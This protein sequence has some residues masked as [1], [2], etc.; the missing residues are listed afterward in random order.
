MR[1]CIDTWKEAG[2]LAYAKTTKDSTSARPLRKKVSN[3]SGYLTFSSSSLQFS[4]D[5]STDNRSTP[6]NFDRSTPKPVSC[7]CEKP[8]IIGEM[9]SGRLDIQT[10]WTSNRSIWTSRS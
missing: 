2:S 8:M 6:Q 9:W 4:T 1:E 7:Q 5:F 10:C 3:Q